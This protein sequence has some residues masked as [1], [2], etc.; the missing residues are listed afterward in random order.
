MKYLNKNLTCA[1]FCSLTTGLTNFAAAEE[2]IW[3]SEGIERVPYDDSVF[4]PDPDSSKL[5]YNVKEALDVYRNKFTTDEPRPMLELGYDIYETGPFPESSF[6]FG[7]KNPV[8]QQFLI[9]GDWQTTLS[10]VDDVNQ[11]PSFTQLATRL[12]LDIDWKLTATERFHM[13]VRP[14]DDNGKITRAIKIDGVDET[15]TQSEFNIEPDAFF[16]EGDLGA[17]TSGFSDSYTSWDLPFAV[18]LMPILFQ[19]GV[20][21][22]DAFTGLAFT[23]PA[24]NSSEWDISNYDITFFAGFDKVSSAISNAD[25]TNANLYGVTA[26][27]DAT[28]GYWEMGYGFTQDTSSLGDQSYHNISAAF[29]KR[30]GAWLSNSL[31]L[32]ANVGQERKNN[33]PTTADGFLFLIENSLITS[34]P[35][36]LVPYFNFFVGIDRP[37]SLARAAGAG[38]VLKNTGITFESPGLGAIPTLDSTANDT[39][40]GAIG[41]EYLFSL[42]QQ[43]VVELGT[44]I[45]SDSASNSSNVDKNQ[46]GLGI[47]YQK[48]FNNRWIVRVDGNTIV[49]DDATRSGISLEVKRKF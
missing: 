34:K 14:L 22:E 49:E 17:I 36:T 32:I 48:P 19:N 26:F 18:G 10:Q 35:S 21:L 44:V 29:T 9:Y 2:K 38:G 23:I 30:Y 7:K 1:L 24:G 27:L 3:F 45:D 33:A 11:G 13:L 16:F 25:E 12:N 31:R 37:Q 42:N 6:I 40:G 39:I 46:F 28:Q 15:D 20:W 5:P 41:V 43:L 4:K 8:T 47:R